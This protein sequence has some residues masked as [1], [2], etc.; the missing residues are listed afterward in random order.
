MLKRAFLLALALLIAV[1]PI[2]Q[3]HSA[4]VSSNPKSDAML[5]KSPKSISL[6]FNEDLIKISGK[7]ISKISLSNT[8]GAVKLGAITIN[9][10]TI[11]AKLLK[12]LPASKYKVTY[13]VVSADGHPISG[14]FF[15]WVH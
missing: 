2:A 8:I 6:T 11:T 10:R 1:N 3:G 5:M 4:L 15:F 9:K 13:R 14:S 7:N 12:T